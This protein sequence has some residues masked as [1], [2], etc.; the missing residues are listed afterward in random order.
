MPLH[1]SANGCS[2]LGW[3]PA[4]AQSPV[5]RHVFVD[6]QLA[7]P[8]VQLHAIGLAASF[9]RSKHRERLLSGKITKGN[10]N[11]LHATQA[12]ESMQADSS[13]TDKHPNAQ[14]SNNRVERNACR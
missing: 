13:H 2:L 11:A 3:L 1:E 10:E 14:H 12:A 9:L 8:V 4:A 7:V 6:A 5:H